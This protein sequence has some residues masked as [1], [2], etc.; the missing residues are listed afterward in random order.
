MLG[1]YHQYQS[2]SNHIQIVFIPRPHYYQPGIVIKNRLSQIDKRRTLYKVI[3]VYCSL[4]N[5]KQVY[6]AY[7][8]YSSSLL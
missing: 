5:T 6:I 8:N 4:S 7:Y 2:V 1:Y 3:S